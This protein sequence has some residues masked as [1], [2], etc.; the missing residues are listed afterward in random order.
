VADVKSDS[1]KGAPSWVDQE[2]SHAVANF[3]VCTLVDKCKY[4]CNST[5]VHI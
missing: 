4:I 5:D 2:R 1:G 3:R